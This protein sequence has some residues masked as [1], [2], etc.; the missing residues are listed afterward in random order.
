MTA[1]NL[2]ISMPYAACGKDC[3]YCVS[4]MTGY[5]KSNTEL[6]LDN[7]WLA[8]RMAEQMG[9]SSVLITS[10]GEP[11]QCK[12]ELLQQVY[13]I[14][15]AYPLE[16]QTNGL[17]LLND[18][19]HIDD[20]L[21]VVA[22]SVDDPI[23]FEMRYSDIW[24]KIS[25]SNAI[26]RA[27]ILMSARFKGWTLSNFLRKCE[28]FNIRQL[29]FRRATIP[30]NRIRNKESQGAVDWIEQ[31]NCIGY[32]RDIIDEIILF[33]HNSEENTL[34]R[35]LPFGAEVHDFDG[36]SLTY[37]DYC[38]QEY[39]NGGNLRSLIY[40]EDGHMYT[41]WNRKGSIIW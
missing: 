11:F 16:I 37:F 19:F 9:V 7:L 24:E 1:N 28:Q 26:A 39:S 4:K 40:Q 38:L 31:H 23:Y 35:K 10:K 5:M 29:T 22:V 6:F 32:Y 41:T 8:E 18:D 17:I 30:E 21:N 12:E 34:V 15:V 36:I 2:T 33:S 25:K 13:D 20:H 14:F 27:T 3:P